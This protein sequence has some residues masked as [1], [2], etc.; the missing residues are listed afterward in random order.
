MRSCQNILVVT[1]MQ[2]DLHL[3]TIACVRSVGFHIHESTFMQMS[4]NI[5]IQVY[6]VCYEALFFKLVLYSCLTNQ[7]CDDKDLAPC[8]MNRWIADCFRRQL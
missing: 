4:R 7:I 2:G 3:H 8:M 6:L 5:A 1:Y